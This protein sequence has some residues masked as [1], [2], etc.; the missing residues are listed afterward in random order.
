MENDG[1]KSIKW[2]IAII[3]IFVLL[4]IIGVLAYFLFF[5]NRI[6]VN[7]NGGILK[8]NLEIKDGEI[9]TLPVIEKEGYKVSA[10]VNENKK[11]VNK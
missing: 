2:F 5:G 11:V 8:T 7:T 3:V 10:Y 6:T 9:T 4:V 1:K